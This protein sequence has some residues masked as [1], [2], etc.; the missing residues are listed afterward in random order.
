MVILH[1]VLDDRQ[2][3]TRAAG[4]LGVALIHAV[5][6]LEHAALMLRRDA[7]AGIGDGDAAAV[8]IGGDRHVHA[9]A[10]AVIL[11]GVVAEVI[12][13]L[14][15][16][17]ANAGNDGRLARD[18]DRDAAR[19]RGVVQILRRLLRHGE[20]V[21]R[22]RRH[23]GA[24]VELG[25]ADDVVDERDEARGLGVNV[26]DEARQ[27]VGLDHAVF[28]Q[29]GAADDA[30][31]RRF[32]FVRDICRELPA[33]ALCELLLR[34]VEGQNDRAEQL[35]VGRDAADVELIHAART[36]GAHL[37]VAVRDGGLNGG[38]DLVAAL[39]GEKVTAH[40]LRVR[41]EE[42]LRRSV[43]AQDAA[44]LV[45]QDKALAHA[46]GDL[47]ELIGPLVQLAQ[48]R[49][50]LDVLA[51][52][53]LEQRGELLI[54]V[55]IERMLEVKTVERVDDAPRQPSGQQSGE[56]ERHDEHNQQRLDHADGDHADRRAADGD[57]QDRAVIEKL[58]IVHGLFHERRGI[59]RA[60]AGASG[61]RLADLGARGMVLKAL[62]VGLG[63][64]QNAA[65]GR[66]PRQ[67]AAVGRQLGQ[68]VRAAVLHGR[69]GK[70][71]LVAQLVFL[72]AAEVIVQKAHDDQQARQQHAPGHE[73]DRLK[74]LFGHVVASMR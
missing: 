20:Q 6:A 10:V 61:Q 21:D 52:D 51:V 44:V 14:V 45:E 39:D 30:L 71:Q 57:A 65:V 7:D 16:Q 19:G 3:E 33:I 27:I 18:A 32:E 1:G 5:E 4:R 29:L 47:R 23:G 66:D 46:A 26:A 9:P 67:A 72:H 62:G 42:R 43:D 37:T 60:L 56:N 64:V 28:N 58:G 49:L 8:G 2:S 40:A 63:I 25:Q 12:D 11:D 17:A 41:A 50:D 24:L 35:P 36:L 74:N 22:F 31:Q 38:A 48:L 69:R 59:A 34:D 54:G 70:A 55:I 13:D 53:A 73:Q 15:D 68:V